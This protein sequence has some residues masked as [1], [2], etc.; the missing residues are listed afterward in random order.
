MIDFRV[1][2]D[3][4]TR[5]LSTAEK[6]AI[7]RSK[8]DALLRDCDWTQLADYPGAIAQELAGLVALTGLERGNALFEFG[9]IPKSRC[10]GF[11]IIRQGLK[12]NGGGC[13]G[14]IDGHPARMTAQVVGDGAQEQVMPAN[15]VQVFEQRLQFVHGV[16]FWSAPGL[17]SPA[18]LR[19]AVGW[20]GG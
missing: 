14:G 18:R 20:R 17:S 6:W 4:N 15:Q 11:A 2:P 13:Q 1:Y 7:I 9:H 8:R 10:N 3:D 19:G 12:K 16:G 5:K